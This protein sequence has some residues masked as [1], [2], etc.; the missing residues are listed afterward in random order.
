MGIQGFFNFLKNHAVYN[1]ET[2]PAFTRIYEDDRRFYGFYDMLVLDYQ[3]LFYNVLRLY[4]EIDYLIRLLFKLKKDCD[5]S[6]PFFDASR[7]PTLEYRIVKY[8]VSKYIVFFNKVG[9]LSST[10]PSVISSDTSY[11]PSLK[12]NSADQKT[13]NLAKIDLILSKFPV[14]DDTLINCVVDDIINHTKYL[15]DKFLTIEKK[16]KRGYYK[17]VHIYFDGIPS[18]AKMKEQLSRRITAPIE[19]YINLDI[20]E[21]GTTDSEEIEINKKLLSNY[22]SIGLDTPVVNLTRSKL[23]ALGFTINNNL[24]YGEAEHQILRD[25]KAFPGYRI[26]LASPDADLIL[27][28]MIAQVKFGCN[29]DIYRETAISEDNYDFSFSYQRTYRGKLEFSSPYKREIYLINIH[30]LKNNMELTNNQQILDTCYLFLL[31]GDDFL[32]IIPSYSVK[33]L[34]TIL[35]TYKT[36]GLKIVDI[37]R[38]SYKLHFVNFKM[39]L[40]L[41]VTS[42]ASDYTEKKTT[43]DS[44]VA[45][46]KILSNASKDLRVI[47]D[48]Y[49]KSS[50]GTLKKQVYFKK[51]IILDSADSPTVLMKP[52]IPYTSLPVISNDNIKKYFEGCKFIFDLYIL[53][54]LKN[55]TWYYPIEDAPSLTQLTTYLATKPNKDLPG[56]FDYTGGINVYNDRSVKYFNV[57]KYKKFI[58]DNKRKILRNFYDKIHPAPVVAPSVASAVPTTTAS[59]KPIVTTES[60]RT[61][62]DDVVDA[63]I[64]RIKELGLAGTSTKASTTPVVPKVSPAPVLATASPAP[65]VAK[66]PSTELVPL[67]EAEMKATFT[68]DNIPKLYTCVNKLYFN[69]CLDIHTDLI[70]PTSGYLLDVADKTLFQMKYFNFNSLYDENGLS[71]DF[72]KNKYLSYKAKYLSLKRSLNN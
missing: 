55:Y 51:G 36:S 28:S 16:R 49:F 32:P 37:T 31:L 12:S 65:V 15:G 72:Y 13:E 25:L 47:S 3:S 14:S 34:E 9:L 18:V 66:P 11:L 62:T 21:K 39:M 45:S 1:K 68:Y 8:I 58:E 22:V 41:L 43:F 61:K 50:S 17:Y 40:N 60:P 7:R 20:V 27:L 59:P 10:N 5:T 38:D 70:N 52:M 46:S 29:I 48:F 26:L 35:T 33:S 30:K 69:K 44:K 4:K 23:S 71:D 53:G 42:E 2:N 6:N 24:R 63:I 56:I 19:K 54:S 64:A 57:E 67:T